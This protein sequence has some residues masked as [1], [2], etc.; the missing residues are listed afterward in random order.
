MSTTTTTPERNNLA[1]TIEAELAGKRLDQAMA[2]MF[3]DYSRRQLQDWIRAGRVTL[4]GQVVRPRETVQTGD[5]IQ[6]QVEIVEQVA[7]EPQPIAFDRLYED[8]HIL[9]I[10]K[11]AG[12]V[13]HPGAGCPN[14]TLQNGLL[15]YEP[16]LI[17][18]PRAGIVHRL[19]KETSGLMVV[20]K[21]SGAYQA[22]VA[23]LAE[24]R[25]QREYTALV[26]G[27]V[28]AG[29]S[30]EQPIGRHPTRRIC[31]AVHPKGRPAVTHYR[32]QQRYAQHT[33]LKVNLETGRTHQIRVHMAYIRHPLCGDPVYGRRLQIP[34]G[35]DQT[36]TDQLRGFKRQALH[37][38]RL[39]LEHPVTGENHRWATPVPADMQHLLHAL[40]TQ[41]IK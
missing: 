13:V 21:T 12:L 29:G 16:T 19:D 2:R 6:L 31:M 23:A 1:A 3:T 10:N 11:P 40:K 35:A 14:G 30:I 18:L 32:I 41:E 17:A 20:A 9:V 27:R 22:L 34:A 24:H 5:H 28:I 38:Q 4:N 25:V 36:L 39:G 37:A 15:H 33:L 7:C 26:V 8:E